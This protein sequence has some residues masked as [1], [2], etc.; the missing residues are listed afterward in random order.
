MQMRNKR[1]KKGKN[2]VIQARKKSEDKHKNDWE[3]GE[4][5]K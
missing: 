3:K 4:K 1:G 2:G 5:N